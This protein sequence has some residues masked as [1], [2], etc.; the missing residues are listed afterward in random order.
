MDS[1]TISFVAMMGVLG[2]ILFLISYYVGPIS[3]GV[4]LDFS[5]VGAIIAGVFGGPF[6]GFASG[7]FV[8]VLPGIFFGPLGT[9]SW[10]GLIGLPIGKALTGLTSGLIAKNLSIAEKRHCS[11]MIPVV[12]ISYIPECLFTIA[13]FIYLMPLFLG[14]GPGLGILAFILP[15]AWGE[16]VI[17]SFLMAALAGN[18]GFRDFV[19]KFFKAATMPESGK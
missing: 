14:G 6:I 10:L 4:A 16:V 8:G 19:S 5:L 15:K 12:L 7:L 18:I 11:L 3:P 1:K 9:G 2:S 17:I 13:Y